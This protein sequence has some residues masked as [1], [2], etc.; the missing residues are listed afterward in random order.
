MH[1]MHPFATNEIVQIKHYKSGKNGVFIVRVR[2]DAK[3]G[4]WYIVKKE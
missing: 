1:K 4:V 2:I 3:N